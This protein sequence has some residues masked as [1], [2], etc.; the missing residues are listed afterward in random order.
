MWPCDLV[1]LVDADDQ[2]A[3]AF[4]RVAGDGGIEPDHALG[5][6]QHQQHHVRHA[7]V[8]ARHHDAQ[9]LRHRLVLPLR[10][11][12]AVSMKTYSVPSR[13]TVSST[14]S[15][16]V[17]AIG[18]TMARSCPVSAFSRVD[19]PTFGR[20]M[21]ATLMSS[22]F[23]GASS[24]ASVARNARGHMVE[25]GVDADAVLRRDREHIGDAELVKSVG[26]VVRAPRYR[27]C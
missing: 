15:R 10:R 22:G 8:A 1:P 5:G 20:P 27:P 21:M 7:D 25:Q 6:I 3:S 23:G 9:L 14:A 13:V 18:E 11:M 2:P 24:A 16:V 12:P 19:L 4:V 17:P 26:Q